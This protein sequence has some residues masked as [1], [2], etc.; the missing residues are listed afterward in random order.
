[1]ISAVQANNPS[2]IQA[3][4]DSS[5]MLEKLNTRITGTINLVS[6]RIAAWNVL[7]DEL[8]SDFMHSIT[9]DA[10]LTNIL[11]SNISSADSSVDLFLNDYGVITSP[12]YTTAIK[13]SA[14]RYRD[15][16]V[17]IYG[18]GAQSHFTSSDID[19][20]RL[21]VGLFPSDVKYCGSPFYL[22]TYHD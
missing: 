10:D 20:T 19:I 14:K 15:A 6:G 2:W 22:E 4:N 11:F 12:V 9:N 18:I 3:I 17:P 7:N 8:H 1:M 5:T 13:E 21:K 16:N